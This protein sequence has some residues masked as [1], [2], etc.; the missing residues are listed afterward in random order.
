MEMQK[1]A[2]VAE[3]D[4]FAAAEIKR[5]IAELVEQMTALERAVAEED[6]KAATA[7]ELAWCASTLRR[8]AYLSH[9]GTCA[10]ARLVLNESRWA[11]RAQSAALKGR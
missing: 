10:C 4:Y 2:A 8:T 1:E 9:A 5:S 3:E 7:E 11:T 6:T